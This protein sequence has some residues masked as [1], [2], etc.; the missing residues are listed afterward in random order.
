M[1]GEGDMSKDEA[2]AGTQI[3]ACSFSVRGG[4]GPG[5]STESACEPIVVVK[6]PGRNDKLN[7]GHTSTAPVATAP[8]K[9]KLL[10]PQR[11]VAL[12]SNESLCRCPSSLAH[13]SGSTWYLC[14]LKA[15]GKSLV[16]S[17][18]T[19][20]SA[21]LLAFEPTFLHEFFLTRNAAF[22]KKEVT[23]GNV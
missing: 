22:P 10:K 12:V 15:R 8:H 14:W 18:R 20:G 3:R 13:T 6:G 9:P 23:L 1:R 4:R 11:K 5:V 21:F 7:P 19:G 16:L 17:S 2:P